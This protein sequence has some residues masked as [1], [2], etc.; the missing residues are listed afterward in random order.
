V[1]ATIVTSCGVTPVFQGPAEELFTNTSIAFNLSFS[2]NFAGLYI[3]DAAYRVVSPN[4]L[5]IATVFTQPSCVSAGQ[6]QPLLPSSPVVGP[7][8]KC[9]SNVT[10]A[11]SDIIYTVTTDFVQV[12]GP[13]SQSNQTTVPMDVFTQ[14]LVGYAASPEGVANFL[15]FEPY[16]LGLSA[17]VNDFPT[18]LFNYDQ[19]NYLHTKI[20]AG[21]SLGLGLLWDDYGHTTGNAGNSTLLS[22]AGNAFGLY[23]VSVPLHNLVIQTYIS[24]LSMA[25]I[26]GTLVG[27][28]WLICAVGMTF[29]QL[30]VINIKA[31]SDTSLLHNVDE[32]IVARKRHTIG[33]SNDPQQ[34]CRM[35]FAPAALLFCQEA[36]SYSVPAEG[37]LLTGK[38]VAI[39]YGTA[40][41]PPP[42]ELPNVRYDYW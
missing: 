9:D 28:A 3:Y 37:K 32:E 27:A 40:T 23:D 7:I 17:I 11:V 2:P 16:N 13:G 35:S 39:V 36:D 8:F 4:E 30:A 42:G 25:L 5:Q 1:V 14:L 41:A 20:C 31:P 22:M 21:A 19:Q 6:C 24:T 12:I 29:A 34:Q 18:G 15:H 26:V 38:R 33:A 10:L